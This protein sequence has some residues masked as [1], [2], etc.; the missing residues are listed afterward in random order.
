MFA[1]QGCDCF[2]PQHGTAS[3]PLAIIGPGIRGGTKVK[4]AQAVMLREVVA[5]GILCWLVSQTQS[6]ECS[7]G[8]TY[9]QYRRLLN[10]C[11]RILGL[12]IG[13]TPHSLRS[14]FA[15]ELVAALVGERARPVD[16]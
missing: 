16:R 2:W 9:E 8:Y 14:G 1:I 4:R 7:I 6:D 10:K 15:S 3:E 5:I 11:E 12:E 13:S